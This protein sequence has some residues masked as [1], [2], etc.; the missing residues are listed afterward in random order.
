MLEI[1][2][3]ATNFACTFRRIVRPATSS[4]DN[5]VCEEAKH[6]PS[7][8]LQGCIVDP[9]GSDR[10]RICIRML[11]SLFVRDEALKRQA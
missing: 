8:Q 1:G 3:I 9:L 2:S 11:K 4:Y 10:F 5:A 6:P 7:F